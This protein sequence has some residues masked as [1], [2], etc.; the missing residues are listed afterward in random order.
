MLF[1][2][3]SKFYRQFEKDYRKYAKEIKSHRKTT[4]YLVS[5]FMSEWDSDRAKELLNQ[6]EAHA[7]AVRELELK[8]ACCK[9]WIK[10]LDE[11]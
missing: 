5:A 1:K 2:K 3:K 4:D 8:Q 10:I 6:I 7:K 9:A 11:A